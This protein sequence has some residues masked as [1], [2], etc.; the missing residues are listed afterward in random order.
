MKQCCNCDNMI[1][2]MVFQNED[3]CSDLCRKVMKGEITEDERLRVLGI[4]PAP[5]K[6][7]PRADLHPDESCYADSS[8]G[9]PVGNCPKC[10]EPEQ[11]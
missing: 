9:H 8:L 11:S 6:R 10:S 5:K 7:K 1:R 3:W 2:A 4:N